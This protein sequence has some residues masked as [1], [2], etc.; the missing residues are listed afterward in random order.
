[1]EEDNNGSRI[2]R[3]SPYWCTLR[4]YIS[5]VGTI[6]SPTVHPGGILAHTYILYYRIAIVKVETLGYGD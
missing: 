1:M 3:L 4:N 5:L 6:T 2:D